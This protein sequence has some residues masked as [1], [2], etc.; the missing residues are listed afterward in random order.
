MKAIRAFLHTIWWW[1]VDLYSYT[2]HFDS[3]WHLFDYS[4]SVM[5][6]S[7][8]KAR[9]PS[10]IYVYQ[11]QMRH[12]ILSRLFYQVT[13][14]NISILL[15]SSNCRTSADIFLSCF[16]LQ[17]HTLPVLHL[18]IHFISELFDKPVEIDSCS[19]SCHQ[20]AAPVAILT[21]N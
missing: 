21:L 12:I 7:R 10:S 6:M 9:Q 18:F 15:P 16:H 20:L 3:S 17:H 11:T 14:F 19:I 5:I 1:R 8:F 13:H 4:N 2:S